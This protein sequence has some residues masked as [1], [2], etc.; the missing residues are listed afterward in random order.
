MARKRKSADYNI[1]QTAA[2]GPVLSKRAFRSERSD[3]KALA[4]H[5]VNSINDG[6]VTTKQA[7]KDLD[8]DV[9]TINNMKRT[10]A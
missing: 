3:L 10:V 7:S 6:F 8:L 5:L 9:N 1:S 4:G 2:E